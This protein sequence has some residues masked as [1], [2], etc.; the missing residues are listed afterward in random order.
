MLFSILFSSIFPLFYI[1]SYI[2]STLHYLLNSFSLPILPST[3]SLQAKTHKIDAKILWF[4][5]NQM[6]KGKNIL[7]T[8]SRWYFHPEIYLDWYLRSE[9]WSSM[10]CHRYYEFTHLKVDQ[11]AFN[12]MP[13]WITSEL[14]WIP[15][16]LCLVRLHAWLQNMLSG[17]YFVNSI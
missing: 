3:K 8:I 7:Q 4:R 16:C 17:K 11:W 10:K 12:R 9:R 14:G 13:Y 15:Q 5:E 2:L 1:L 6:W